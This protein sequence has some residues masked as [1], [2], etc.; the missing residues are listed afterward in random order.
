MHPQTLRMYERRGLLRPQ[1]T[2]KN[3]RRYSQRDVERLRRIQELTELGLNLAGVERVLAME[4]QLD[5]MRARAAAAA[6]AAE[7]GRPAAM[8]REVERSSACR[9]GMDSCPC[10]RRIVRSGRR[11]PARRARDARDSSAGTRASKHGR[12][13]LL[14]A[15][16]RG[17]ETA[18]GVVRRGPGNVL[19]TEH[20]L[21]GV[22]SLPGGVVEQ[23]LNVL[24]VDKGVLMTRA[25]QLAQNQPV[26]TE[27]AVRAR[28]DALHDAARQGR[29]RHRRAGG[30]EA[31]RRVR[32]HRA[33]AARHLPRGRGP[34][35]RHAA[36]RRRHRGARCA[37]R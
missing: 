37:A 35:Q 9:T 3:T 22:L 2:A 17:L 6:G 13:Q 25:N 30:P 18:Q 32:R 11:R 10:P 24:G 7:R 19:G 27:R 28:R 36:R 31:G 33:P 4:E 16:P 12:E 26:G 21:I 34:G 8:R 20:L 23:I 15:G 1:R 29:P 5:V 14:R